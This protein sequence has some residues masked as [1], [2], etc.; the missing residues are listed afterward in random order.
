MRDDGSAATTSATIVDF[1][2]SLWSAYGMGFG[3]AIAF[4]AEPHGAPG[5]EGPAFHC[6][7]TQCR[8]TPIPVAETAGTVVRLHG[9][10]FRFA[11]PNADIRVRIGGIAAK[12][13]SMG[14]SNEPGNDDVT[15][16]LPPAMRGLGETDVICSVNGRMANVVR[17]RI[18]ATHN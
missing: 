1:E 8:A 12:V 7:R 3:P 9:T 18:G 15:I 6:T 17:I 11:G 10:G 4:V 14:A 5:K 2:P 13:L 16:E